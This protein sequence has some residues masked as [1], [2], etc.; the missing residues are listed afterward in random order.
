MHSQD[1][2]FE[3][4]DQRHSPDIPVKIIV[5]PLSKKKSQKGQSNKTSNSGNSETSLSF[6]IDHFGGTF[7]LN[8]YLFPKNKIGSIRIQLLDKSGKVEYQTLELDASCKS[9]LVIREQFGALKVSS[10]SN[11]KQGLVGC[12]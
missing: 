2:F 12:V 5:T 4:E 10:F 8:K 1:D 3:C 11:G 9:P 7:T 6:S